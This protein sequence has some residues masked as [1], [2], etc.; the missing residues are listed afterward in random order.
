[1]RKRSNPVRHIVRIVISMTLILSF[2]GCATVE[3][4]Y[5]SAPGMLPGTTRNM[6]TAGYWIER[7]PFPDRIILDSRELE[8]LNRHIIDELKTRKDLLDLPEPYPSIKIKDRIDMVSRSFK[9]RTLF[10]EKG[11]QVGESFFR[12]ME[13]KMGIDKL[14]A[15]IPLRFGIIS[16]YTNQRVFP[17]NTKI[18]ANGSSPSL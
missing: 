9:S 10:N 5:H 12:E 8:F 7:H 14:P 11:C 2:T 16:H 4:I 3:T 1:M 13:R 17:T 15:D 6:K 18:Y